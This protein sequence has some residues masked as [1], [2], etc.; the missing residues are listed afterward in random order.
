MSAPAAATAGS[1]AT[2]AQVPP[3]HCGEV[4][5][6]YRLC[7]FCTRTGSKIG[8]RQ[9][10]WHVRCPAAR[11]Q[12]AAPGTFH[13]AHI[14]VCETEN[15]LYCRALRGQGPCAI[16]DDDAAGRAARLSRPG[17]R[18]LL[19]LVTGISMLYDETLRQQLLVHYAFVAHQQSCFAVL[20]WIGGGVHWRP[21]L[22]HC[23]GGR[24][25][26]GFAE[27]SLM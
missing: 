20:L 22:F 21:Q 17:V 25:S 8:G 24:P 10:R 19:Q 7:M 15:S 3:S 14:H 4:L 1:P 11:P 23:E 6:W 18:C 5:W 16:C 26:R 27:V 9:G 13:I 12:S 2:R